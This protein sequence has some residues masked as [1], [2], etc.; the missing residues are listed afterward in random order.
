VEVSDRNRAEPMASSD[1]RLRADD[2]A[3]LFVHRWLPA[4]APKAIVLIVHGMAEHAGRYARTADYLTAAGFGVY[5]H[6][7]RGHGRSAAEGDLGYFGERGGWERLTRDVHCIERRIASDFP[8]VPRF[9]LGHSLGSLLVRDYL[10]SQAPDIAGAVL[11]ATKGS[12]GVLAKLGLGIALLERAR[13]GAKGHSEILQNLSFGRFNWGFAPRRTEFD[14]LSRDP[15][16]VDKYVADPL[17]GFPLTT[18]AWVDVFGGLARVEQ[19]ALISGMRPSLPLYLFAGD[20]DPVGPRTKGV[21]WL[22]AA[23]RRLGV[24]QPTF[25]FYPQ[26][27]HE[28]FNET[29]RDEVHRDLIA[30]FDA[31]LSRS[32]TPARA[33]AT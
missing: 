32:A 22:L 1:F 27:R 26:G 31:V 3:L 17:C 18:Q 24:G 21:P 15:A 14:W 9:V 19:N 2:G 4:G 8:G 33:E 16:E 10:C 12:T 11:S 23:Y 30:W 6:D 29:N 13:V 7:Q 20:R 25:K 5:A 28:M